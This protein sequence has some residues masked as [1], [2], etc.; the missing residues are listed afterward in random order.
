VL[1][2]RRDAR[3][4]RRPR[5]LLAAVA[6]LLATGCAAARPRPEPPLALPS[7]ERLEELL[8]ARHAAA[9]SVRG[10]ARIVYERGEETVG[11]RHAVV[12]RRPDRLRLE[13]L[14]PFGATALVTSNG[15]EF[16]LYVRSEGRVYRG[17][18]TAGSIAAYAALPVGAEDVVAMLLGTPPPRPATGAATVA[19]EAA[20]LVRLSVPIAAGRQDVWFAPDTLWPVACETA[21]A[22]GRTL[23]VTFGDYRVVGA[24]VFPHSIDLSATPGDRAVRVRWAAP[25]LNAPIADELFAFP[26][27]PGVEEHPIEHYLGGA[28]S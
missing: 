3:A 16:A 10:L 25:A 20:G 22:D 2:A 24:E 6:C 28:V 17:P 5:L 4:G 18:A 19:R 15:R 26:G 8:A 11:A 13:V 27:R 7:A 9:G 23:R 21:L 14:A 1:D 12:A